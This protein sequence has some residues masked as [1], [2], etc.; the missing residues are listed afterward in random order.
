MLQL[1]G[2]VER[3]RVYR[4]KTAILDQFCDLLLDRLIVTGNEH[5]ERLVID[6]TRDQGA[7]KGGVEGFDYP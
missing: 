2:P 1:P 6:L 7:G 5:I 3:P 4:I